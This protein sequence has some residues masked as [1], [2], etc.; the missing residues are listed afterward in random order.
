MS[1]GTI[2]ITKRATGFYI[3]IYTHTHT[4][5]YIYVLTKLAVVSCQT[6]LLISQ[7]LLRSNIM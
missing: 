6:R 3:Y 7:S 2:S 5:T 1:I 4:H